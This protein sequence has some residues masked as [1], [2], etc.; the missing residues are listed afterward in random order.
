M[1]LQRDGFNAAPSVTARMR[2]N[3]RV[4]TKPEITLRRLLWRDGLRFRKDFRTAGRR[5][6]VAFPARRLAVQVDGCFWHGC[7]VHY[8][9]PKKN[10]TYWQ[11][12]IQVVRER[13]IR[14]GQALASTGWLVLRFWEHEV[15]G[16]PDQVLARIR[17]VLSER[18]QMR[19]D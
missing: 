15:V 7:P 11:A 1:G 17:G 4:D 19:A 8:S 12:K 9:P 14:D 2:L 6:D 13:D 18:A 16:S 3:R 5:V 10:I